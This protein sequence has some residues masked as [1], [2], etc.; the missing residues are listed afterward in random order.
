M[1]I[2]GFIRPTSH[3]PA[4][5]ASGAVRV[6]VERN[7]KSK[8]KALARD[9]GRPLFT[10]KRPDNGLPEDLREHLRL[11][12]DIVALGF[13]TDKTRGA[14]MLRCRDVSGLFHPFPAVRDARR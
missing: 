6:G 14:W 7:D 1:L 5:L 12:C 13:P 8:P 9:K 11:R 10:M 2:R 4:G 3:S